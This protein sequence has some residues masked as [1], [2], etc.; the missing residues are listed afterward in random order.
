MNSKTRVAMA[1]LLL[2]GNVLWFT[3]SLHAQAEPFYQGK[4]IRIVVGFT[5]GGFY[6]RWARLLARHLPKHI[7]GNP[8]II[9]QNMPGAGSAIAANY[10][11]NVAKPDGLTLGMASNG[12]YLDQLVGRKEVQFDVRKFVY[13]GSPVTEPMIIYMRADAPYK[14]IADIRNAKEPPKCGST[15]TASSDY[16]L[17]RLLEDALPPLKIHTVSGYPGGAE[18]DIAAERGEVVCRGMTASPFF[19]REPFL[20]WQKNNFVRVLLYTGRKRDPRIPDTPTLFEIFER[21]KVPEAS[22]RVAEVLLASEEFGRPM[23]GPP[24]TPAD[25]LKVLRA[26]YERSMKDAEL[27]EEA[28]KGRMDMDPTSGEELEKLANRVLDQPAEVLERV[29][30]ILK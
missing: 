8:E 18:I 29:K 10:V 4:S 12:I 17:S 24:G 23:V 30:R 6:D 7:P 15:G 5:T 11:Y 25:R 2:L 13:V 9:V 20:T 16:I 27:L 28:K 19:G 3:P 21:E 14:S 22:R 1:L 26:A